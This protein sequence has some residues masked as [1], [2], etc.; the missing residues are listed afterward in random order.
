[1]TCRNI[2]GVSILTDDR[3]RRIV[4]FLGTRTRSPGVTLYTESS[5]SNRHIYVVS[6]TRVRD[7]ILDHV[8]TYVCQSRILLERVSLD[9]APNNRV[10]TRP[11]K[12]CE[13]IK[14]ARSPRPN[15]ITKIYEYRAITAL[16]SNN[17]KSWE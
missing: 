14:I 5:S 3:F 10:C 9:L 4:E 12:R 1:M 17:N 16:L 8:C 6:R 11:I 13:S 15:E 2:T 7:D